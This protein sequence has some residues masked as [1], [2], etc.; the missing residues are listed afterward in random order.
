MMIF[1]PFLDD[2][3][4]GGHLESGATGGVIY[5]AD[6]EVFLWLRLVFK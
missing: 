4:G 1:R 5:R 6:K 2:R 3:G